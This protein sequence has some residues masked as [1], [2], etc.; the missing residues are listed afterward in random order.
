LLDKQKSQIDQ[1]LNIEAS[2]MQSSE[3]DK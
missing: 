3:E 1:L 2:I